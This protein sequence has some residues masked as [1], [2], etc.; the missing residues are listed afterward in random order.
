MIEMRRGSIA[1]IDALGFKGLW[2]RYSPNS[3]IHKLNGMRNS[4]LRFA[5]HGDKHV[6]H[7]RTHI[8]RF[9]SDSVVIGCHSGNGTEYSQQELDIDTAGSVAIL[10]NRLIRSSLHDEPFLLYRGCITT[11]EY[12]LDGNFLVGEAVDEAA[13]AMLESGDVLK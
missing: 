10:T 2:Q 9:L 7:G 12:V 1:L 13:E 11:G 8:I 6:Q 3:I 4:V 5:Q